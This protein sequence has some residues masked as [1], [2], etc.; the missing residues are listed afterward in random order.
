M[1]GEGSGVKGCQNVLRTKSHCISC[2]SDLLLF[3]KVVD[4]KSM[5]F[6]LFIQRSILILTAYFE[7]PFGP[8]YPKLR[9]QQ[10]N[11]IAFLVEG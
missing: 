1:E 6:E 10:T 5:G 7:V 2:E 11:I 8:D 9:S 3:Q 4:C